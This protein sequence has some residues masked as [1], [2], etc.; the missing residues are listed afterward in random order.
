MLLQDTLLSW[1]QSVELLLTSFA[2]FS[3]SSH[4]WVPLCSIHPHP[5]PDSI[6]SRVLRPF[7]PLTTVRSLA[8]VKTP[9]LNCLPYRTHPRGL[10]KLTQHR[11][12]SWPISLTCCCHSLPHLSEWELHFQLLGAETLASSPTPHV[13]RQ[14]LSS[15]PEMHPAS[16]QF[17]LPWSKQATTDLCNRL[18]T[19]LPAS[20]P[21][22][23]N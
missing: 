13:C 2:P 7:D 11:A 19:S 21:D 12:V 3:P 6:Y 5:L 1:F 15:S 16:D 20:I 10:V 17:L 18:V 8:Q 22:P 4:H 9:P 14:P 23:L